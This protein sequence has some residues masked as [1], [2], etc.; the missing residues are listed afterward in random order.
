MD[1]MSAV[2]LSAI[3]FSA[4]GGQRAWRAVSCWCRQHPVRERG[5]YGDSGHL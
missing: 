2:F 3:L 5:S 1:A 4:L